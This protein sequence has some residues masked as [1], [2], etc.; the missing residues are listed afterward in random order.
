MRYEW[1]IARRYLHPQGGATFIFHLTLIS[2]AGVA[3]GVASLITVLSV[4]NGFANDLRTKILEGRSHIVMNYYDGLDNF[5]SV[6]PVFSSIDNVA[7]CSPVIIKWGMLFPTDFRHYTQNA[8]NFVGID[9]AYEAAVT[10]LD[11]KI[12]AGSLDALTEAPA[13]SSTAGAMKITEL[14]NLKV[15]ADTT[16]GILIGKELASYL[17]GVT[18]NDGQTKPDAF[19]RVLGMRITLITIPNESE[20]ISMGVTQSAIFKV[21]GVFES[22]HYEFDSA[23]VYISIPSAQYLLDIPGKVTHIEFRLDDHSQTKTDETNEMIYS[24]NRENVGAR[25]YAETWMRMNRTFFNALEYEK[26]TM[27][28]I[29][30]IIILVATFNIIATLF[31]VVTEKTRDIGLLRA[32]GAGRRNIMKIFLILGILVGTIGA[33]FGVIGGY[34]VCT[35]L[36][37][38][39]PELPGDGQIYYLKYLPCEME[40]FD[41]LGA[42]LYTML[43]SFLASIY[44]AI[45]ASRFLP[46]EA[47]RFS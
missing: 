16:P 6:L 37:Q 36:Q 2:I 9:P 43:V 7:A 44:P 41:F 11:E 38:F 28:Y 40:I 1:F 47:L 17:F 24:L 30:K 46:V 22:G 32:V 13:Q 5:E 20:T 12:I 25:G 33:M 35:F 10:H 39:P 14:Q 29:L 15:E 21:V 8:V 34:G 3:L 19:E 23:W 27:N 18:E 45:R 31:M 42:S 26:M 4:M